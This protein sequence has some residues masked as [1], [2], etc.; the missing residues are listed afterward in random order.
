M[1]L[2]GYAVCYFSGNLETLQSAKR[3]KRKPKK[4]SHQLWC[5]HLVKGCN[6]FEEFLFYAT[7]E[8]QG[9][10]QL[11]LNKRIVGYYE[12]IVDMNFLGVEE[13][14][15]AVATSVEQVRVCDLGSMSCSY[16]MAGHTGMALC[17]CRLDT[18]TISSGRTL[19][20][21]CCKYNNMRIEETGTIAG[22]LLSFTQESRKKC[23]ITK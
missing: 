2:Y 21:T 20:V 8:S 7:I 9:L 12:E 15:L 19:I 17:L 22:W 16:V 1:E 11:N 10:F 3:M 14:F 18:C 23:I 13:Q 6:V 5:F 4:V